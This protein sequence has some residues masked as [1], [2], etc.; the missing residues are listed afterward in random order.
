MYASRLK[1]RILAEQ[2]TNLAEGMEEIIRIID[3]VMQTIRRISRQLRPRV[4]DEVGLIPAI[5]SQLE[6]FRVQ[7]GIMCNL[8]TKM[9]SIPIFPKH[10]IEVFR[11]VQEALTNIGRHSKA[12]MVNISLFP[13]DGYTCLEI[14]DNGIG[15]DLNKAG[16]KDTL[17]LL[18]MKERAAT[19]KGILNIRSSQGE[20]TIIKL[21]IP[22]YKE[23][24]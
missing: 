10:K 18:G 5:V 20:G 8:T 22:V 23:N 2:A 11:I 16:K 21:K 15:I 14:H 4:L 7:S 6:E 12:S 9:E 13:Q 1:N 19:F 3:T 17:G 24:V